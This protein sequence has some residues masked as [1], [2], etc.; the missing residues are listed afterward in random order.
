[1]SSKI[2]FVPKASVD[3]KFYYSR[4]ALGIHETCLT[5]PVSV[6]MKK[7]YADFIQ[8]QHKAQMGIMT[9]QSI[10]I[11][12]FTPEPDSEDSDDEDGDPITALFIVIG[13]YTPPS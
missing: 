6:S 3:S 12:N 10:S 13:D 9:I 11:F 2:H 8:V 5:T 4:N 7:L 1:M